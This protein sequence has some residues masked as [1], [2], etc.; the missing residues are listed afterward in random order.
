MNITTKET[1][2]YS[3]FSQAATELGISFKTINK[4]LQIQKE[5]KNNRF[6]FTKKVNYVVI[7]L[8]SLIFL[9]SPRL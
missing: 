6:Y 5:Y 2:I 3:S 9:F 8:F 7:I 4:Y 1:K